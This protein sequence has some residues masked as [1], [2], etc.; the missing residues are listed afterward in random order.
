MPTQEPANAVPT[1]IVSTSA[2]ITA[3]AANRFKYPPRR[4]SLMERVN[5]HRAMSERGTEPGEGA[6][7]R[8][9]V[10]STSNTARSG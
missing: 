5:K 8:I 1:D 2:A 3:M 4:P 7:N 10:A 9:L 6:K